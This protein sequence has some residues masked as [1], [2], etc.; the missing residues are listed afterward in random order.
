[1]DI[2]EIQG[3]QM[4]CEEVNL[5]KFRPFVDESVVEHSFGEW[6]RA[7]QTSHPSFREY[8]GRKGVNQ[9]NTIRKLTTTPHS[10]HTNRW[11]QYQSAPRSDL[12]SETVLSMVIEQTTSHSVK[13]RNLTR[14]EKAQHVSEQKLIRMVVSLARQQ[15]TQNTRTK[16]M[17]PTGCAP[18]ALVKLVVEGEE[19]EGADDVLHGNQYV[20][21]REAVMRVSALE[22]R[23]GEEPR[24]GSAHSRSEY[25]FITQDIV[26]CKAGEEAD[27]TVARDAWWPA[28]CREP[29]HRSKQRARCLVKVFLMDR[30]SRSARSYQINSA[31]VVVRYEVILRGADGKPMCILA[32]EAASAGSYNDGVVTY[33]LSEAMCEMADELAAVHGSSGGAS[34][35]DEAESSEGEG[36]NGQ[37]CDDG[38]Q[39]RLGQ[40]MAS[41][42]AVRTVMSTTLSGREAA[43]N[44]VY[45]DYRQMHSGNTGARKVPAQRRRRIGKEGNYDTC[46]KC[47]LRGDLLMC[48]NCIESFHL[49][50]IGL[51]VVPEGAWHCPQCCTQS[52]DE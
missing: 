31:A 12:R 1:M 17:R 4:V 42:E 16:Y 8:A 50:C 27:G 24:L 43:N 9:I 15:R 34:S 36:E 26:F 20:S 33:E 22:R 18:T 40:R 14:E 32:E 45:V 35:S 28:I 51:A 21:Y 3:L 6:D 5:V 30:S 2:V 46:G 48:D 13:A 39:A 10:Y 29:F 44:R 52:T 49:E 23:R 41:Q 19:A 7:S 38:R 11:T 47:G 25:V 37:D